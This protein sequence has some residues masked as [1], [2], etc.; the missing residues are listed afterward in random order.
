MCLHGLNAKVDPADLLIVLRDDAVVDVA[1][2]WPSKWK[3]VIQNT[4]HGATL[5]ASNNWFRTSLHE[6]WTVDDVTAANAV[7]AKVKIVSSIQ[8]VSLLQKTVRRFLKKREKTLRKKWPSSVQNPQQAAQKQ[9]AQQQ[10]QHEEKH[11][12]PKEPQRQADEQQPET[13]QGSAAAVA[14]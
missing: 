5:D 13:A 10:Q 3:V 12:Q 6:E 14:V 2:I 1:I 7:I 9:G 8:A 4:P 11:E